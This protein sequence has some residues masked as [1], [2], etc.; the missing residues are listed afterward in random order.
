MQISKQSVIQII[1]SLARAHRKGSPVPRTLTPRQQ[2]PSRH[3]N[4]NG[5][6]GIP[7]KTK[8]AVAGSLDAKNNVKGNS[9]RQNQH[10]VKKDLTNYIEYSNTTIQQVQKH[11]T[12]T[13][14]PFHSQYLSICCTE[15]TR[16][17]PGVPGTK[18]N[19][20]F[21]SQTSNGC[22]CPFQMRCQRCQ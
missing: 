4:S 15:S 16:R 2:H 1:N 11:N 17:W 5:T 7:G 22:V 12:I 8:V 19:Q 20:C 3:G 10:G 9:N 14:L 18:R 13:P 6:D 21:P